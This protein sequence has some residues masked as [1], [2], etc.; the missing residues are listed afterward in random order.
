MSS[1][2]WTAEPSLASIPLYRF[3]GGW[4]SS[5]STEVDAGRFVHFVVYV[6][7]LEGFTVNGFTG[8]N[9]F[10]QALGHRIDEYFQRA[11]REA[12][13]RKGFREGL[14]FIVLAGL[15][16]NITF[17]LRLA[18]PPGWSV[19]PLS[20]ADLVTVSHVKGLDLAAVFKVLEAKRRIEKAGIQ[21]LNINGFLNLAAWAD[22]LDG[23]LVPPNTEP[24]AGGPMVA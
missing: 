19:E 1:T 7:G 5:F 14:L 18:P 23:H 24:G 9:G 4:L 13:A 15:G 8:S 20:A 22:H 12:S 6:D 2:P 11:I 21:F 10:P 16:R 17:P 3:E